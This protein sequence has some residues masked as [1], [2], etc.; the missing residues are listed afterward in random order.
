MKKE[1][2]CGAEA[3]IYLQ[4]NKVYKIRHPKSYRI[5][6]LD[7]LLISSRTKREKKIFE[8]LSQLGIRTPILF[9]SQENILVMEYIDAQRLRDTLIASPNQDDLIIQLA[10]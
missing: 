2:S 10:Q 8:K 7:S 4:D 6:E 5:P 3:S 1:L 9:E